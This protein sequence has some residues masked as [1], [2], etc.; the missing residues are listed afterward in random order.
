MMRRQ[1]GSRCT[2][3]EFLCFLK[4]EEGECVN[5]TSTD[6]QWNP[7]GPHPCSVERITQQEFQTRF[8]RGL[9]PMFPTPIVI[10][11]NS[12]KPRNSE[13]RKLTQFDTIL[14]SFP[15]AFNVTLSSSNSFSEHRK[16]IPFSDYLGNLSATETTP[17]KLSNETW[18]FF[19]ETFSA[20]WK[21][22]LLE[23]ELPPCQACQR[24]MVALSFGI[25]NRGSGVQWHVHGPGFAETLWGRKHWVLSQSKP[26]FHKDQTSRNWMEYQ[27]TKMPL[28]DRPLECTISPGDLIYF[29]DMWYHA[30]IN[31]DPYT[32]FV[33]T[34]TQEHLFVEE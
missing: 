27:Y 2:Q 10:V 20:E 34:F 9:P 26:V 12:S 1:Q 16:T 7:N 11:S 31:L 30:I 32:V 29:P 14:D 24:D 25:G 13:V 33:S 6:Y 19:G 8:P 4:G 23:Y 18:Y 5:P 15:P 3:F 17:D 22:L 21:R 28:K